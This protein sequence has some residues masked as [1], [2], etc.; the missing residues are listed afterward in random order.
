MP[1][2]SPFPTFPHVGWGVVHA[3]GAK[4]AGTI[5][6]GDS[7]LGLERGSQLLRANGTGHEAVLNVGWLHSYAT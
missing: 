6:G 3:D 2:P 1:Q 4:G 5:M 7:I